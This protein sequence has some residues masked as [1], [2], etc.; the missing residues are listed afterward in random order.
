MDTVTE[1]MNDSE[2]KEQ[3]PL[4]LD[5]SF[6]NRKSEINAKNDSFPLH[7]IDEVEKILRNKKSP[8]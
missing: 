7:D 4:D 6:E 2:S 1:V 5:S 8:E 3:I